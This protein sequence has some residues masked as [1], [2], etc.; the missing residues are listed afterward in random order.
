MN[1]NLPDTFDLTVEEHVLLNQFG[2][3]G[4]PLFTTQQKQGLL[5]LR[6]DVKSGVRSDD[7]D[8]GEEIDAFD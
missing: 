2:K 7:L 4:L 8:E 5:H 6:R 1:N 3:N